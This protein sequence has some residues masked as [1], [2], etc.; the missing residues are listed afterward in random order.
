MSRIPSQQLHLS[1]LR[2]GAYLLNESHL[3]I[4]LKVVLSGVSV[5]IHHGL[6]HT[7][8]PQRICC[9]KGARVTAALPST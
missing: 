4:A 7:Y 6:R 3:V 8:G 9:A 2:A 1:V 5:W